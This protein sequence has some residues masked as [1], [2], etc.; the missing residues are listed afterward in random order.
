MII[1]AQGPW[2]QQYIDCLHKDLILV[3]KSLD[4]NNYGILL[5]LFGEA[6][7][8]DSGFKKH[9]DFVKHAKTKAIA[10]NLADCHTREMT[11]TIFTKI[12]DQAGISNASFTDES[13]AKAWLLAQLHK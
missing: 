13:S 6:L 3:S 10:L 8:V 7:A 4:I 11:K 1:K 9:L 12:Y 2:N 5:N